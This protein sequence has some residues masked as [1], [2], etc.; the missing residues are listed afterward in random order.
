MIHQFISPNAAVCQFHAL[1]KANGSRKFFHRD[2][3][4]CWASALEYTIKLG[5]CEVDFRLQGA[6]YWF[7]SCVFNLL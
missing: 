5:C 2:V 4:G 7:L 1:K 6:G 3:L